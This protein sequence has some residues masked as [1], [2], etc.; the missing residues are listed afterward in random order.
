M[1]KIPVGATIAHAYHFTF[2]D[3]PRILGVQRSWWC[4]MDWPL[5][6]NALPIAH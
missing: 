2:E 5:G 3:F 1:K 4:S 6:R